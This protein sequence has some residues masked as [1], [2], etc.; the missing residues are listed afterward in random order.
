[1][2]HFVYSLKDS[3]Q[4]ANIFTLDGANYLRPWHQAPYINPSIM[5]LVS[6][7]N[8]I[9]PLVEDHL[10]VGVFVAS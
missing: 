6:Y 1:M 9:E 7:L 2:L 5:V 4:V 3:W 10:F 8:Y